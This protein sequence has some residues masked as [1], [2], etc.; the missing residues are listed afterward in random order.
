[1]EHGLRLSLK[2]VA[3]SAFLS[4]KISILFMAAS[5]PPMSVRPLVS[6]SAIWAHILVRF[7]AYDL[8]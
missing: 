6:H 4:V 3:K 2:H 1:M 8:C 7:V 5:V